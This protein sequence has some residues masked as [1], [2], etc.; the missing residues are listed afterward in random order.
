MIKYKA[1]V[2]D[3]PDTTASRITNIVPGRSVLLIGVYKNFKLIA[4]DGAEGWVYDKK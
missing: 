1:A 4:V 3:K 2:Y